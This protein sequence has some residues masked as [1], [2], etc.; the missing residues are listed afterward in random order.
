MVT[1]RE[2]V[3]L[4]NLLSERMIREGKT[5]AA[6]EF[7]KLNARLATSTLEKLVHAEGG[8]SPNM[9]MQGRE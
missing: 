9:F 4:L 1:K 2:M 8:R 7:N 3:R 5:E 6:M